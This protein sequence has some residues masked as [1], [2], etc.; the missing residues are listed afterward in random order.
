MEISDIEPELVFQKFFK[1]I[2]NSVDS[3][4]LVF[5]LLVFN[6]YPKITEHDAPSPSIIQHIMT[7]QKAINKV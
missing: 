1:A 2:N 5:I 3:N 6:T 7:M 4:G